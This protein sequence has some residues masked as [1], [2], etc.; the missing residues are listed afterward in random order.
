MSPQVPELPPEWP[1]DRYWLALIM[2]DEHW[3]M[4]DVAHEVLRGRVTREQ[5][6]DFADRLEKLAGLLR[7][8]HPEPPAQELPEPE[9][10]SHE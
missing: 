8:H 3:R 10:R 2:N 5:L 6:D 7:K 9:D 1:P 4:E